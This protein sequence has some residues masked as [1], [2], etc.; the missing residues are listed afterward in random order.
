MNYGNIRGVPIPI[1]RIVFGTAT[2]KLFAAFRSVYGGADDFDRRLTDAFELLDMVY[3]AGVNCFDC[4]DHYGEEPLGE[5][6]EARGLRDKV[7]ILTKGA[8]HNAWRKRVTDFDILHDVHNSLAKLKTDVI[9]LYLLHRDDPTVPVAPIMNALNRCFD[10]GKLRVFGVSNWTWQRMEEA[11]E[12][13]FKHG[14]EP[15]RV[16]SPN[17]SLAEQVEDPWG[18]GCQSI[19]GESNKLAR[20]WVAAHGMPVFAYS[21]LARGLFSGRVRSDHPEDAKEY[22]D[23]F[24]QKGY[25]YPVN[26]ARLKRCE[27]LAKEK[28]VSVPEIAMAWIFNQRDLDVYALTGTTRAE[29][30][31]KNIAAGEMKLTDEECSWLESGEHD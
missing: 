6:L 7:V 31:A 21:P 4:A 16:T 18:G 5:W 3:A 14:L 23:E 24:A 27:Q 1:S 30:L 8:H 17:F 11:N 28:G 22:M 29:N 12:Y 10:E 15:F 25:A 26:F 2:S 19:S 13:A 20:A 9:D